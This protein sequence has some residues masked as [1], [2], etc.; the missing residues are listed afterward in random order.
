MATYANE[1]IENMKEQLLDKES[2]MGMFQISIQSSKRIEKIGERQYW[3][4][5]GKF[6]RIYKQYES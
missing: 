6:S 1:E 2:Q 5:D 4:N 3:N